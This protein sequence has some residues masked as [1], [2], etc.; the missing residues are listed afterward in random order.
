MI[1]SPVKIFGAVLA[2]E[3]YDNYRWKV[4]YDRVYDRII[5][6]TKILNAAGMKQSELVPLYEGLKKELSNLPE[7]IF[8]SMAY[9]C[10]M[11]AFLEGVRVK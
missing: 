10:R 3:P 9:S 5:D 11:D 6:N 4:I 1:V 7:N 2:D 8:A